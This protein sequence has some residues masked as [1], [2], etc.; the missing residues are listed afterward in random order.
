M[1][2]RISRLLGRTV[3]RSIVG[4]F[5]VCWS[6]FLL[7]SVVVGMLL[8]SLYEQSTTE[9][10]RRAS[11]AVAHGCDAIAA[12]YQFFVTGVTHA[13]ADLRDADFARGLTGVVQIALRDLYGVEGGIWQK[14]EGSLA[15]AFPTYEGTGQKTDLPE[16][17]RASI[18]EAADAAA[19]DGAPFNRRREGRAQ[20]LLLHA[21]PLP[22]PIPGLSGWTMARVPTT[23]G[24]AYIQAVAGLGLL[25]LVVLGS[26]AWLGRLLLGWSQ[27]LRR[28]ESALASSSEE[29]PKLDHT[30]QR[31]LD[32]IVEAV[33]R[34]G[35]RLAESRRTSE[36]M[37]RQ[38]AE[39]KRLA[40]L[41]RVVAGVAHEIRNPIA[42]MRLKAEN[43]VAAGPDVARKDN[44][45][46][47][48]VEQ[49]GRLET[50]L[51]NLLSSVQRAPLVSAPVKDVVA[52]LAERVE[53][54][55]EQAALLGG[56]LEARGDLVEGHFDPTRIAQ[57]IDN[58]ILNA[59][60]NTPP[61]GRVI[62]CAETTGDRVLLVVA[63][64]GSGVPEELRNH[65]FEPFVTGRSEGTGLG[66]AVVREIAEAHGG[67]A[68]AVHRDD[69][70]T[71]VL[72]LPWRPS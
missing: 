47:V 13:P 31:D 34:A 55:R 6:A 28:L 61:G 48:I 40:T 44:A 25:L 24:Q 59:L 49:I 62:L 26:A 57:A 4:W 8:I 22:G 69:G 54:F 29:L 3:P 16:A 50:L 36:A 51:R 52:F 53:L 56:E 39:A 60:Q 7:A 72:E 43:A 10:L 18:R 9:Q 38:V 67:T 11:A 23:G 42:A 58:L 46:K 37:A 68:R 20:T 63:D 32:R 17:E 33:N 12:R 70:T 45:L 15:Y 66:P 14:D 71:F 21:C 2:G 1:R 35:T 19:L 30:G 5:V 65:L 41:G 27:R 64:T